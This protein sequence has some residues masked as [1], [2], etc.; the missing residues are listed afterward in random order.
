MPINRSIAAGRAFIELFVKDTNSKTAIA[1]FARSVRR[2]GANIGLLG[3]ALQGLSGVVVGPISAAA[4]EF[5]SFGDAID[6]AAARTGAATEF[7]SQMKFAAEQSGS[8]FN[9]FVSGLFRMERR[10]ANAA[11]ETGPAVRALHELNL[12]AED[13]GGLN[14]EQKFDAVVR[15]LEGVEDPARRAQLGFE[16]FGDNIRD[17]T[18]LLNAGVD[19]IQKLREEASELGLTVDRDGAT[20]AARLSDA[21]NKVVSVFRAVR[22]GIGG[23]VADTLSDVA[24][25]VSQFGS[26]IV[27]VVQQNGEFIR[28]A[29][30]IAAIVGA[31]GAAITVLGIA[32]IG[33]GAVISASLTILGA[34]GTA[35]S[36][37]A[38][39]AAAVVSPI[40]L[41]VAAI[42]GIG[43]AIARQTG[44]VSQAGDFLR[45][46]FQRIRETAQRA[47][48][49]IGDTLRA[50]NLQLA[51]QIL[52]QQ[53]RLEWTRGVGFLNKQWQDWKT[54]FLRVANEAAFGVS[55]AL[56]NAWAGVQEGFIV[57]VDGL[58]DAW[59]KFTTSAITGWR[60]AQ[61]FISKGIVQLMGLIDDSVDVEAA[62][63]ILDE[64]F[65][66]ESATRNAQRDEAIA[67]RAEARQNRLA[68]I[69]E[70]RNLNLA[71][72]REDHAKKELA[73]QESRGNALKAGQDKLT[74]LQSRY[75]QSLLAAAEAREAIAD[76]PNLFEQ[77]Q[78]Q[79]DGFQLG[80]SDAVK[81][82]IAGATSEGRIAERIFG[83][84]E[85]F[86]KRTERLQQRQVRASEESAT[87]I[88]K[89]EE[90]TRNLSAG[91][92]VLT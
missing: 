15:A 73:I 21:W 78:E 63:R 57:V 12:A 35:F 19:G 50:G 45:G 66:R 65:R 76:Q 29:L 39:A 74:Q 1:N 13:F 43:V 27:R 30:Q 5:A 32:L 28:S 10:I 90:N 26:A 34:L 11:T 68:D 20:A 87:I 37:L 77:F 61:N 54:F 23:A 71:V 4:A 33:V 3:G 48:Q 64:D 82:S 85:S 81:Q 31:V 70:Q 91:G 72:L 69:E 42:G 24:D 36:V 41:A 84:Q 83:G 46:V 9:S 89:V 14:A 79:I 40:G 55:S 44:V 2:A 6:K 38:T 16:I 75:E 25:K 86:R 60:T 92:G 47:F 52:W 51:A 80:V 56:V 53:L 18:P 49:G 8:S 59:A 88:K 58:I 7:L 17:L 62:T 67:K 22:L